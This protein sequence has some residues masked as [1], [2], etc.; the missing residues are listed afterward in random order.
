M[1]TMIRCVLI[2]CIAMFATPHAAK[3]SVIKVYLMAG[4]SN[5]DGAGLVAGLQP[6]Y[7]APQPG[8]KFWNNKTS[9]WAAL[10]PGIGAN[11]SAEFGPELSFGYAMHTAF[12]DDAICLIKYAVGATSLA[13]DWNPNG[14]GWCYNNFKATANAAIDRLSAAGYS[15][16]IAGMLW[17]Q[18]ESDAYIG[19]ASVYAENLTNFIGRVRSDF[20]APN[21]PFV[22]GRINTYTW[23][24]A[25]NNE[26]VREAQMAVPGTVD[27]A[28]WINTDDLPLS[29]AGHFNTQG[30]ITLGAR[31]ASELIDAPEPRSIVTMLTGLFGF[32]AFFRCKR[33]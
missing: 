1:K 22:I 12:P 25:A 9:D 10:Q 5:M 13:Y 11:T 17:M 3:A 20:A 27:N 8:V 7:S 18:G 31:F 4:Q 30:Q 14:S 6:P 26:L 2:A 16:E 33:A 32:L 28:S 19:M 21:M 23:G 24:T 15:P 29:Y